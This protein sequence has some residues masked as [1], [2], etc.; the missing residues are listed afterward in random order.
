MEQL[1]KKINSST[2]FTPAENK[3]LKEL[4][5]DRKYTITDLKSVK[6]RFGRS[7]LIS[8]YDSIEEKSYNCFSTK[9]I[10]SILTD[11]TIKNINLSE[12]SLYLIYKGEVKAFSGSKV[13]SPIVEFTCE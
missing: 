12:E 6:T 5:V 13:T 10:S 7:V 4:T 3:N 9:K 8:L 2:S 1:V 11:E